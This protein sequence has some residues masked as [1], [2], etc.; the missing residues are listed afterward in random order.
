MHAKWHLGG[1]PKARDH[2]A[3]ISLDRVL[4]LA[5]A[6]MLSCHCFKVQGLELPSSRLLRWNAQVWLRIHSADH[7]CAGAQAELDVLLLAANLPGALIRR[8]GDI[9]NRLKT[10]FDALSVPANAWSGL[11][12][13]IFTAPRHDPQAVADRRFNEAVPLRSWRASSFRLLR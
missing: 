5:I 4:A 8:G 1:L 11:V 10:L 6:T 7:D 2:P 9:D 3:V 13:I 12:Q